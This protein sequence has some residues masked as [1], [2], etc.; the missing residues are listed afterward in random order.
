M[1]GRRGAAIVAD[2]EPGISPS[3]WPTRDEAVVAR[4][5]QSKI[6]GTS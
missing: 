5:L 3:L 2:S 1:T 4:T 6:F